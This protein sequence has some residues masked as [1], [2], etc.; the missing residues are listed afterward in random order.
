MHRDAFDAFGGF[1]VASV[2][3]TLGYE[4]AHLGYWCMNHS[5][6]IVISHASLVGHFAF[7]PQW[8]HMKSLLH[9]EPTLF[10]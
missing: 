3:G 2:P 4:E 6:V 8:A 9:T 1:A 7:G 10:D 5:H